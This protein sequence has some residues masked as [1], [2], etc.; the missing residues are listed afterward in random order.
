MSRGLNQKELTKIIMSFM[1]ELVEKYTV[2][3]EVNIK[4]TSTSLYGGY[5]TEQEK[6]KPN[7]GFKFEGYF[8][9]KQDFQSYIDIFID[10]EQI[11]FE[12]RHDNELIKIM[13]KFMDQFFE[14]HLVLENK[15]ETL[16]SN[17]QKKGYRPIKERTR[18]SIDFKLSGIVPSRN[19]VERQVRAFVQMKN[20]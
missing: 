14:D 5:K 9:D 17:L 16:D 13:M 12:N 4:S 1:D 2:F 8:I 20:L 15:K 19:E 3:E 10:T 7:I 6:E 11:N 18:S